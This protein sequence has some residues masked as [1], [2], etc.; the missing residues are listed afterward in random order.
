MGKVINQEIRDQVGRNL[1]TMMT[2]AGVENPNQF[3]GMTEDITVTQIRFIQDGVTGASVD[4]LSHIAKA[5][6]IMPAFLLVQESMRKSIESGGV[7]VARVYRLVQMYI[8]TTD[9]GRKTLE[10]MAAML[11]A[12][13]AHPQSLDAPE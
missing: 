5:L 7:D 10:G 9:E 11:P 3:E 2:L 4:A 13:P 1:K 12:R 6:G 8:D